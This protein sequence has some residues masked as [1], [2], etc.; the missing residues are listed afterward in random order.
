MSL[1][2]S[3]PTPDRGPRSLHADSNFRDPRVPLFTKDNESPK[4]ES[5]QLGTLATAL[6]LIPLVNSISGNQGGLLG[7]NQGVRP[8]VGGNQ[9]GITGG[10]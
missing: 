9:G 10:K 3:H 5:K 7:G 8:V 6:L 1:G 4:L 2:E